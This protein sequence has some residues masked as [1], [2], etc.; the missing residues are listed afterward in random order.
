MIA[1]LLLGILAVLLCLFIK[2][3]K[4]GLKWAFFI[5]TL[6]LSVRYGWGNDYMSYL[7]SFR[8][9]SQEGF[10]LFDIEQSG[11]LRRGNEYGWVILNRLFGYLGVGFFGFVIVLTI[12]EN[13]T[14]HRMVAKYVDP[15]YYWAAIFV[16]VFSTSFCVNASM[17]RQY[18]CMCIYLLVVDLMVEKKYKWYLILSIALIF[19][20]TTIHRSSVMLFATLPL[21]YIHVDN[22]K[23][24]RI[25]MTLIAVLFV[26]WSVYGRVLIEPMMLNILEG[27]EDY[28]EYI[29]YIGQNSSGLSET[30]LGVIFR[31]IMFGTWL[32]LLPNID[33]N[34]QPIIIL[35]IAS[36]FLEIVGDIA[37][38]AGRLQLY[39]SCMDLLRWAWLLTIAK[40]TP[41]VYGLFIAETMIIVKCF[42]EFFYNPT[43]I[44]AY[45]HFH[46]IFEAGEWM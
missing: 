3:K 22:T 35:G 39:F 16:F 1:N 5:I 24:S 21:F 11:D 12:F 31:Y 40:K 15:K 30:G 29:Q 27:N 36:Y 34:Q 2:D 7:D 19:L 42:F 33:K 28:S 6:F 32:L 4:K 37:P 14:V 44:R 23:A 26:A 10:K 20:A 45:L 13:W 8:E 18:L 43:W 25:W 38:I 9:Y 41:I 17:L 46:T